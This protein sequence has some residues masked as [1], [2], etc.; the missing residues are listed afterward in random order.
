VHHLGVVCPAGPLLA[1][2]GPTTVGRTAVLLR[3]AAQHAAS[4]ADDEP[5]AVSI[6][7]LR[8]LASVSGQLD[9]DHSHELMAALPAI[10]GTSHPS[11]VIDTAGVTFCDADGL[12][13]LAAARALAADHGCGLT[14]DPASRC[15]QRLVTLV[16][17]GDL[18]APALPRES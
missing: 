17:L 6:D 13:T 9:R 15:V 18:L 2:V 16:G 11:W 7:P 8:G 3:S 5:L 4:R 14:L 10:V 1:A 12:R